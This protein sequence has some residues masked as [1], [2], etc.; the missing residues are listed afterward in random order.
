MYAQ[1]SSFITDFIG[2]FWPTITY[3]FIATF[4]LYTFPSNLW[5]ASICLLK[6]TA[7]IRKVLF[8]PVHGWFICICC[9]QKPTAY[10]E[11]HI[12]DF[13]FKDH[14]RDVWDNLFRFFIFCLSIR[15]LASIF[16]EFGIDREYFDSFEVK[17]ICL[18]KIKASHFW[19]EELHLTDHFILSRS[20]FFSLI[21]RFGI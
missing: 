2:I 1:I 9:H 17:E 14:L 8:N 16:K 21:L 19:P 11:K 18:L 10:V 7:S 15:E 5:S 4:T 13:K 3:W 20:L 6:I 12:I